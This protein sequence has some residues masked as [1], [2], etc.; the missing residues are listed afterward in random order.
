M[1][2]QAKL[3]EELQVLYDSLQGGTPK[4]AE[5]VLE[6]LRFSTGWLART[7]EM[8]ADAEYYFNLKRGDVALENFT[9]SA[10]ILKEVSARGCAEEQRVY[11]LAERVNAALVHRIDALRSQLSFEKSLMNMNNSE[12]G[13]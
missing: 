9:L 13:R 10:T 2:T 8:V 7:A 5:A 4:E 6:D 3:V 12:G 11:R 1:T